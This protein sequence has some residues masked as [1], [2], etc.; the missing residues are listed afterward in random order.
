MDM[1]LIEL[2][3]EHLQ[4][5]LALDRSSPTFSAVPQS[6][7]R[8]VAVSAY[9]LQVERVSRS[10]ELIW[11]SG[12]VEAT[13]LACMPYG[14]PSLESDTNY[15]WRV[16]CWDEYGSPC[17]WSQYAHIHT[18]LFGEKDWE[19][20]WI[21]G[22]GLLRHDFTL[23]SEPRETYAFFC[24]LGWG[25]LYLNGSKVSDHVLDPGFTTVRGS[26]LY[27]CYEVSEYLQP[28]RNTVG[29]MLGDRRWGGTACRL[30]MSVKCEGDSGE[31]V[32]SDTSWQTTTG[33][34]LEDNIYH[35]EVYDARCEEDGWSM[36]GFD[37]QD[38]NDSS[39]AELQVG[40]LSAQLMP[41]I[42][43]IEEVVPFEMHSPRPG[44]YVFDL[45]QNISGWARLRV[46]G[47]VG[48]RVTLRYGELL[49]DDGRLNQATCKGARAKDVYIL[50]GGG[51]EVYEPRFTYHGFRY[52]E[53]RDYPGVPTMD[54]IRGCVVHTDSRPRGNFSCSNSLINGIQRLI[55][56]GQKTNLHSIPT[57]CCNRME[58]Q[59]WLGDAHATV[60]VCLKNFDT[61]AFYS[62][63]LDR[64]ADEQ[65]GT[66]AVPDT[67]PRYCVGRRPAD[68]VWGAAYP[69]ILWEHYL[70][71]A[72]LQTVKRHYDSVS[73]YVDAELERADEGLLQAG[74]Y[75]DWIAI[76]ESDQ[77]FLSTV[78]LLMSV[79]LM[80]DL[81]EALGRDDEAQRYIKNDKNVV[82]ALYKRFF[83]PATG[84]YA[85]GTQTELALAIC[86]DL[87]VK[88]RDA[89]VSH[90]VHDIVWRHDTHTTCGF[91]GIKYLLQALDK[92]GKTGLAYELA[93]QRTQ[94]SWGY[95]VDAGATT[96]WELW[97]KKTGRGMN[98]HNH[99]MLGSI[100]NWFH[101]S[102]AGL[103]PD[104]DA[105]GWE[106]FEISPPIIGDLKWAGSSL[107]TVRGQVSVEWAQEHDC[108]S[109]K[110]QIPVGST[111]TLR[112]P[113]NG[114]QDIMLKENGN[115]IWNT[116]GNGAARAH[117]CEIHVLE[118]ELRLLVPS[119]EYCFEVTDSPVADQTAVGGDSRSP[120]DQNPN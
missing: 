119:G 34:I 77:T 57:D 10:P 49:H 73:R 50:K 7:R 116:G 37:D 58:R 51:P 75:G 108:F 30:Q 62:N 69:I 101:T 99:P 63:F 70:H 46:R 90:L 55:L 88:D 28:G 100:G 96:L 12:R 3:C 68:P 35:G 33:P 111:A 32:T 95:M 110:T 24:G 102:L 65:D 89:V 48:K 66:G 56:W 41:P 31:M 107:W 23:P 20:E 45:G 15:R 6:G 16:R 72:D 94:P 2:R 25:E 44:V 36:P 67:V 4:N 60:D 26:A 82:T 13:G 80:A 118:Q 87:P 52:V 85:G 115:R 61:T 86:L 120:C 93:C 105:P 92:V 76:E 27:V 40:Q 17:R 74:H 47:P 84:L 109:L 53:V 18:G 104:P 81:S 54:A 117:P 11:D 78:F 83:N 59:G 113:F 1:Q 39:P 103:K 29:V 64:I 14:G 38:W 21:T 71:S 5:P 19:A 98:S 42:R 106:H 22:D 112:I 8:D 97:Q 91:V 79:R 114:L 43:K 9:Q